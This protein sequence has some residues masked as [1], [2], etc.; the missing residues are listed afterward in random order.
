[1][2]DQASQQKIDGHK[3]R[4]MMLIT[5]P[6]D[7]QEET[8]LGF[9]E[10]TSALT[11]IMNKA[12]DVKHAVVPE[13]IAQIKQPQSEEETVVAAFLAKDEASQIAFLSK[14]ILDRT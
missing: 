2:M 7:N 8:L 4:V 10:Q 1:M 14:T 5:M 3:E 6:F 13:K 12:P 11:E 9:V